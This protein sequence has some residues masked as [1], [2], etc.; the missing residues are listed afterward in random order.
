MLLL[1][2]VCV[3]LEFSAPSQANEFVLNSPRPVEVSSRLLAILEPP[4]AIP[5]PEPQLVL[6]RTKRQIRSTGDPIW[7][8]RLEIPGQPARHFDAV[9][10][11]VLVIVCT[12]IGASPPTG[13]LPT[14]I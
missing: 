1:I 14:I 13:T 12:E 3:G 10:G 8:L 11:S 6:N 5:D 4:I 2:A 7:D 9:S